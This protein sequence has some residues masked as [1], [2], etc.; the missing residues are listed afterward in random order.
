MSL[1][2]QTIAIAILVVALASATCL[3][4]DCRPQAVLCGQTAGEHFGAAVADAGDIDQDGVSDILVGAPN[5]SGIGRAYLYSG[6]DRSLMHELYGETSGDRFGAALS[7]AGDVDGDGMVDLIIAAP[8]YDSYRGRVYVF[9]GADWSTI[10]TKTGAA[11]G[12]HLGYSVAGMGDLNDDNHADIAVGATGDDG[13]GPDRGAVFVYSGADHSILRALIGDAYTEFGFSI[14]NGGDMNKDGYSD[15]LVGQPA[16]VA[17][18]GKVYVFNGYTGALIGS[19]AGPHS[20][21]CQGWSVAGIGDANGDGYDDLV[22]GV[23][24]YDG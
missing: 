23:P 16:Y 19:F 8:D 15:L 21:D 4:G 3:A 9:S 12:D 14:A 11:S 20:A 10:M 7:S 18:D 22:A 1:G 13:A 24:F 6:S 17:N 2:K 5:P